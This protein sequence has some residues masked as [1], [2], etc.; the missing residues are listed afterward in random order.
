LALKLG[1]TQSNTSR[2]LLGSTMIPSDDNVRTQN[3][4]D[5]EAPAQNWANQI[6]RYGKPDNLV[7]SASTV[8][9]GTIGSGEGVLLPAKW[10][11]TEGGERSMTTQEVVAVAKT[12]K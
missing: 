6:V 5:P 7:L 9:R 1:V 8:V 2:T 3:K 12:F 10:H 4:Q 11:L